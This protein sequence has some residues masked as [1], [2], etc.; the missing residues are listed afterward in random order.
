MRL[1]KE[2]LKSIIKEELQ[3]AMLGEAE[4]KDPG[5]NQKHFPETFRVINK[6]A[7][8]LKNHRASEVNI[9]PEIAASKIIRK[10][11]LFATMIRQMNSET[12]YTQKYNPE[13][14]SKA[15]QAV[16][17][18]GQ[19]PEHV[20]DTKPEYDFYS[21]FRF[22]RTYLNFLNQINWSDKEFVDLLN[23]FV[24]KYYKEK[25]LLINKPKVDAEI[26]AADKRQSNLGQIRRSF[27][28]MEENKK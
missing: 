21:E 18:K 22:I 6:I 15:L 11:G 25:R 26:A 10:P 28:R 8:F 24:V 4:T 17:Y 3:K 12:D 7:D 2:L 23:E 27:G 19:N 5:L 1:T 9:N 13:R 16:F 14:H 20:E